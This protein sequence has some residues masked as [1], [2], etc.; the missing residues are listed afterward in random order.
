MS[1]SSRNTTQGGACVND[2][3]QL[4]TNYERGLSDILYA[5]QDAA[6]KNLAQKAKLNTATDEIAARQLCTED[7]LRVDDAQTKY[8]GA[9]RVE[10]NIWFKR[11]GEAQEANVAGQRSELQLAEQHLSTQ[12]RV[13]LQEALTERCQ[14]HVAKLSPGIDVASSG[15]RLEET[16][17]ARQEWT[18]EVC[19]AVIMEM[20]KDWR[21]GQRK[22]LQQLAGELRSERK[23]AAEALERQIGMSRKVSEHAKGMWANEIQQAQEELDGVADAYK[24]ALKLALEAKL[25]EARLHAKE[26][27]EFFQKE[28]REA[29]LF[30]QQERASHGAQLRRMRLAMLKWR[31]DYIEDAKR[32]AAEFVCRGT[33]ATLAGLGNMQQKKK[34]KKKQVGV[35]DGLEGGNDTEEGNIKGRRGTGL[36][37]SAKLGDFS[38]VMKKEDES[39][40]SFEE[41][42]PDRVSNVKF[43][44]RVSRSVSEETSTESS[45]EDDGEGDDAKPELVSLHVDEELTACRTVLEKLWKRI[46]NPEEEATDFLFQLEDLIPYEEEVLLLYEQECVKHGVMCSLDATDG[47]AEESL[48]AD[49]EAEMAR[50]QPKE[51]K[52]VEK[53]RSRTKGKPAVPTVKRKVQLLP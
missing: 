24:K 41:Q 14:E 52:V 8:I 22:L 48:A 1:A 18:T 2:I 36:G 19:K 17:I 27:A 29:L 50:L 46:S 30:E 16:E 39:T 53:T 3:V 38:D 20:R 9:L 42:H 25:R 23:A 7:G 37:G 32:K 31:F 28:I 51:D 4:L 35:L 33:L 12:G 49:K 10:H 44:E 13:Q 11:E 34:K 40:L 5:G 21:T 45:S 26:Q 15:N 43:N 6:D 47:R